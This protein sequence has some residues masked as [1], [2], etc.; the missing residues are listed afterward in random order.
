MLRPERRETGRDLEPLVLDLA[1]VGEVQGEACRRRR[2]NRDEQVA[3]L[4]L[5]QCELHCGA[6]A[7]QCRVQAGLDLAGAL[8][9][10]VRVPS[11]AP[12]DRNRDAGVSPDHEA[13]LQRRELLAE[14]RLIPCL[15]VGETQF[16]LRASAQE[17][18][19]PVGARRGGEKVEFFHVT[20]GAGAFG[21]HAARH[22]QP[23]TY[24]EP[25]FVAVQRDGALVRVLL[26]RRHD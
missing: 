5:E 20:V 8:G 9:L 26:E 15:A 12:A 18:R 2:R 11:D 1:G 3:R 6:P 21:A 25:L 24:T 17:F 10:D 7:C 22:Q 19:E 14:E 16:H 23:L 4:A 13:A